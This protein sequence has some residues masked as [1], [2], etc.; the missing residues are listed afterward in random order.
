MTPV[1]FQTE[2]QIKWIFDRKSN[3]SFN[4]EHCLHK[5]SIW[6]VRLKC[7]VNLSRTENSFYIK[8]LINN[9][10]PKTAVEVI[11][12]QTLKRNTIFT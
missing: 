8:A 4:S 7:L 5:D 3:V 11:R 9:F 12:R 1:M 10:E 6:L 2:L